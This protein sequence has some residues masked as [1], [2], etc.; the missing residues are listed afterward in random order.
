MIDDNR[1]TVPSSL[2]AGAL[3]TIVAVRFEGGTM[4]IL[5]ITQGGVNVGVGALGMP[6]GW[7][8]PCVP[9]GG[10]LI[11]YHLPLGRVVTVEV[12]NRTE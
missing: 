9:F 4:G 8:L 10:K 6:Q 12:A 2:R 11:G 1:N 5:S 7:A 3:D